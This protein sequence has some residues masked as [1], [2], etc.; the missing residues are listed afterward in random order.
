MATNVVVMTKTKDFTPEQSLLQ[1]QEVIDDIE[2][3][4]WIAV[5]KD[6]QILTGWSDGPNIS[7]LGMLE[8]VRNDI[9]HAMLKSEKPLGE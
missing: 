3:F 8:I 9:L 1:A 5:K 2:Q 4:C 7:V 6:G